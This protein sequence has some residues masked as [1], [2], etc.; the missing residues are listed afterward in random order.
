MNKD[1]RKYALDRVTA[2][3]NAKLEKL[4]EVHKAERR[5]LTAKER[6]ALVRSGKVKLK[7]ECTEIGEYDRYWVYWDFSK[8]EQ[9]EVVKPSYQ[10]AADKVNAEAQTIRDKIMLGDAEE[11]LALLSSFEA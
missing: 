11:A 4:K 5:V 10:P 2:I 6:A 8:Y 1:Q 9:R 3:T 7:P